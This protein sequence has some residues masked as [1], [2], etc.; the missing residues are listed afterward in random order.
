MI[1]YRICYA[2]RGIKKIKYINWLK[3]SSGKAEDNYTFN[4]AL[5]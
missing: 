2:L 3:C 1:T 4:F 5:I